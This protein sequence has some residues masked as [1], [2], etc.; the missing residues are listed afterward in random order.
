M[1]VISSPESTQSPVD[2]PEENKESD[3]LS[4]E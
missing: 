1:C 3:V 4:E 2:L